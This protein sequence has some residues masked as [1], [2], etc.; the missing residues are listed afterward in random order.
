MQA[1]MSDKLSCPSDFHV[2]QA[3][4][5]VNFKPLLAVL[6]WRSAADPE[7]HLL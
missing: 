4:T 1:L 5:P 2:L 3:L 6:H 7:A